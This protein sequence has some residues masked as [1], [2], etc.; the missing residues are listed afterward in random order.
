MKPRNI[1]LLS[2]LCIVLVSLASCTSAETPAPVEVPTDNPPTEVPPTEVPPSPL[3]SA[4]VMGILAEKCAGCHVAVPDIHAGE[5]I[6]GQCGLCHIPFGPFEEPSHAEL[7]EGCVVCH[8]TPEVT[9][10]FLRDEEDQTVLA[11][12]AEGKCLDCHV[13]NEARVE[14]PGFGYP[15]LVT[16]EDVLASVEQGTLRSWIQPG[17]FMAKYAEPE[18]VAAITNWV[19]AYAVD[20][21]IGYDPYLEA[22]K[23]DDDFEISPMGDNPA[24]EAAP[25][26]M[27]S[28]LPTIYTA[29]NQVSLKAL[30]SDD[31]LYI[32]AEYADS[33]AS[34]T[35]AGSWILEDGTWRHPVAE[36][37]NDKQSEDRLSIVWN[38]STPDFMETGGCASKC[39]GNVPGSSEFTDEPGALMDIWHTKAARGMGVFDG[40]DSDLTIDVNSEAF[41][42]L[43]GSL[44][45]SGVLDD[46]RLVW[47]M[48]LDDGYDLEDSGRRGDAGKSAYSHNR[49]GDKSAPKFIEIAPESWTDAM[50]L[51]ATETE[52]GS[53]IVAD[54]TDPAYN[55]AAVAAAW[56]NY[57]AL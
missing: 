34:L 31:Y 46:K 45:F 55:A 23:I 9:H 48:D 20:Q 28:V 39:H 50:V 56:E 13:T 52:D 37:E 7:T 47:Y 30:Y 17:G 36:S 57:I 33:T 54:S 38:I 5:G 8:N 44:T 18:E 1:I 14:S 29:A 53:T 3:V 10:F 27:V 26:H 12:N 15:P 25:E 16:E 35:R 43:S 51:T 24:W 21:E 4:E 32:R 49:N 40:T 42:V 11:A 22:V 2:L 41:E 6:E 19:D